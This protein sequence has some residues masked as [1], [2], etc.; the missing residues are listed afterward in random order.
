MKA[1]ERKS[2]IGC[3]EGLLISVFIAFELQVH[4]VHW[5]CDKY[6]SFEEAVDKEDG[7]AVLGVF[8]E[9][10]FAETDMI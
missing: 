9:V 2:V 4:F 3:L 6:E 8:L 7:L 10:R 5:N 1:E